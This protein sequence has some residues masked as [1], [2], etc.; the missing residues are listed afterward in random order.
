MIG[1]AIL[2]ARK[3]PIKIK[4]AATASVVSIIRCATASNSANT[5]CTGTVPTKNQSMLSM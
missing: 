2:L 1:I 4:M 3:I 5:S